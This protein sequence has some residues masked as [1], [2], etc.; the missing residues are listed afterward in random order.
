MKL[1]NKLTNL[2]RWHIK[3]HNQRDKAL[4]EMR[5]ILDSCT[6]VVYAK[7]HVN[8]EVA[9]SIGMQSVQGL[10]EKNLGSIISEKIFNSKYPKIT[11]NVWD[12]NF[13]D[14]YVFTATLGVFE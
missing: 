5:K 10:S 12:K 9:H 2:I 6:N 11:S 8:V 3:D 13:S 14:D 1:E 4:E 7:Y